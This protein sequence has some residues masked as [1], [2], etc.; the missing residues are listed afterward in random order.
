M[1][2]IGRCRS[3]CDRWGKPAENTERCAV[4]GSAF[5]HSW[6]HYITT[7]SEG[8]ARQFKPLGCCHRVTLEVHIQEGSRSL[9]TDKMKSNHVICTVALIGLIM[10]ASVTAVLSG[11]KRGPK[12]SVVSVHLFNKKLNTSKT[13]NNK[14]TTETVLSGADTQRL[15]TTTH[16]TPTQNS[17]IW[18]RHT[19]T[20]YNH[21][22]TPTQKRI[23]KDRTH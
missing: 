22:Q 1:S 14:V 23:D 21:P 9:A 2:S 11:R 13:Q 3:R 17:S 16:K 19:K 7:K 5:C 20:E 12:R 6:G 15:K 18:C 4:I 8:R 10:S